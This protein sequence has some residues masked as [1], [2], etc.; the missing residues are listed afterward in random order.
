M[1]DSKIHRALIEVRLLCS[2]LAVALSGCAEATPTPDTVTITLAHPAFRSEHFKSM[3][4]EFS[5]IYPHII[6]ELRN[7]GYDD[8]DVFE[9]N[10][11]AGRD[12]L[13]QGEVLSLDPI[14]NQDQSFDPAD[15]YPGTMGLF[16]SEGKTWAVP[17]GVDLVVM[18]YN[19]DLVDRY[20]APHPEVGWTWD[21]F[22]DT[23]L[24]VR[25][26]EAEVFGYVPTPHTFGPLLF[27]Y[28]HGGRLL[29]DLENPT[30]ITFDDPLAIE[31]VEWYAKLTTEHEVTPT[32]EQIQ[33][34]FARGMRSAYQ[35][36]LQGRAAM[37]MGMLSEWAEL[38]R[39][40]E[41]N[42][43]LGVVPLPSDAR[44]FTAAT[45]NAYA[46]SAETQYPNECWQL[47]AFLSK[48]IPRNLVPARKSLTE[49]AEYEQLVGH[50][51]AVAARSSIEA[52]TL[53]SQDIVQFGAAMGAFFQAV[54]S[55]MDAR[56][57]AE[58]AMSQ[59]QR[60]YGQ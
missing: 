7:S 28:Q 31:A 40:Q 37:W 18:Y 4:N 43:S 38:S 20:N 10:P 2:L 13:G 24:A 1:G 11:F 39:A 53:V 52:A 44:S 47:V 30:Y 14:I 35:G 59:L 54:E 27:I 56:S 51:V 19:Q 46:I 23:A 58:E 3:V 49:S 32:L 45:V 34:L 60:Q 15:F 36:V 5:E 17:T 9:V 16:R 12:Q 25:D 57:T 6:V 21:D 33:K 29:D 8:A 50:E 42:L 26:P 55:V 22:L 41:L 48:Q